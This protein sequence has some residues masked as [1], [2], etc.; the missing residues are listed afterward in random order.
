MHDRQ[1]L[2]YYELSMQ[3]AHEKLQGSH[4]FKAVF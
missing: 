4:S 2:D 3:V 1:V